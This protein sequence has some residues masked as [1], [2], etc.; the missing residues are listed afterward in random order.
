MGLD[1]R[2]YDLLT[3]RACGDQEDEPLSWSLPY[4]MAQQPLVQQWQ[5]PSDKRI[6][7]SFAPLAMLLEGSCNMFNAAAAMEA[8]LLTL[9]RENA[10]VLSIS[11]RA[12]ALQLHAIALTCNGLHIGRHAVLHPH[13]AA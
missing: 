12:T 4:C 9:L 10:M 6:C 13:G 2:P 3:T 5:V 11:D 1:H 8:C 7:S